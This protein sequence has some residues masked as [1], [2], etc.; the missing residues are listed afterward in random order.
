MVAKF[1]G[2]RICFFLASLLNQG[3]M[4]SEITMIYYLMV[5]L[6]LLSLQIAYVQCKSLT[7]VEHETSSLNIALQQ[8]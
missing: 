7:L 3:L 2:M 8:D 1:V 6:P 5:S 4:V